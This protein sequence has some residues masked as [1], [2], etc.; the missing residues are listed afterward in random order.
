MFYKNCFT[1]LTDANTFSFEANLQGLSGVQLWEKLA[2]FG[3][4]RAHLRA[5]RP[6]TT[7]TSR[8]Y[9]I[10][11]FKGG[12]QSCDPPVWSWGCRSC[13]AFSQHQFGAG[14]Y[15]THSTDRCCQI[16]SGDKIGAAGS[17]VN[18]FIYF[19]LNM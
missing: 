7:R 13:F 12:R 9:C 17:Y 2:A 14:E 10:E 3:S 19:L 6:E 15:S 8:Y 5:P 4:I 11:E 16:T 1:S 18:I